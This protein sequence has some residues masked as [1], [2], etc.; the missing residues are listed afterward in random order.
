MDLAF[1]P[2][3]SVIIPTYNRKDSLLRT[4]ESLGR[5]TYPHDRFETIVV[6]DGGSDGSEAVIQMDFPFALRY[7]RQ[8]NQGDAHARNRG[9]Q[10]AKGA[11]LQ[12]LDDDIILDPGFLAAVMKEHS[13]HDKL[14]VIGR[15]PVLPSA[16][17]TAFERIAIAAQDARASV[18]GELDF[19]EILS[20][21]LSLRR[22]Y[23][24]ALGMMQPVA[25]SGS[26][27][28][29]D[30][31]FSYRAHREGFSLW[32]AGDAV[33]YHDDYALR[34]F[35]VSCKRA[36][37]SAEVGAELFQRH[38]ELK[39]HIPMFRDK[40]PIAWRQDPPSLILRKLA[41]QVASSRPVMG[42]MERSVPA[43]EH[44]APDAKVLAL[45]YRWIIS[46]YIY[47][48]YRDGLRQLAEQKTQ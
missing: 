11:I 26:S 31:E 2:I 48:G 38:P 22:E 25:S 17:P 33:A 46:G 42:A 13:R 18:S 3:I 44:R 9:A 40:G 28:W 45:F 30:V 32:R 20:G 29:C 14:M 23:Y 8:A 27:V 5:Q 12:F 21:V 6:D 34:E 39:T 24:L 16:S 15:L 10:E 7:I 35:R 36:Y 19:T 43:L 41:R 37:R 1:N 47:R 4:L